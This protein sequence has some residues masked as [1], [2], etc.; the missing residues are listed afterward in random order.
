MRQML[1]QRFGRLM[2]IIA[3]ADKKVANGNIQ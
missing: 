3:R 2:V 1:G